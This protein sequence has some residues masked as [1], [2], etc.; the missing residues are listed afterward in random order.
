MKVFLHPTIRDF[1]NLPLH[2][3]QEE[4]G[5][6]L[7]LKQVHRIY[8]PGKTPSEILDEVIEGGHYVEGVDWFRLSPVQTQKF[9]EISAFESRKSGFPHNTL[10][11][12]FSPT[13]PAGEC[14][15]SIRLAMFLIATNPGPAG[16][17]FYISALIEQS[18]SRPSQTPYDP[19]RVRVILHKKYQETKSIFHQCLTERKWLPD[20][21]PT[22]DQ[23]IFENIFSTEE[24]FSLPKFRG[25]P[26]GANHEDYYGIDDLKPITKAFE[27]STDCLLS[28]IA[29]EDVWEQLP[30]IVNGVLL[31]STKNGIYPCETPLE[32]KPV[33]Q[34][35]DEL[36][37]AGKRRELQALARG[38]S[39]LRLR[40]LRRLNDSQ[41]HLL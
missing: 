30:K 29:T 5:N 17:N 23:R 12:L 1:Q 3:L 7:S 37:G 22:V 11:E 2:T 28:S 16:R 8:I 33:D 41:L 21:F 34:V 39:V 38:T 31:E 32:E 27:A 26:E 36:L 19:M 13:N 25:V 15:V 6:F 9:I 4:K 14:V 35:A 10:A 20:F 40:Q 18:I 24:P